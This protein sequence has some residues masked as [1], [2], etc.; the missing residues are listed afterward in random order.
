MK[1]KSV[2][3]SAISGVAIGG[4][5][6]TVI[7]VGVASYFIAAKPTPTD[8]PIIA[9]EPDAIVEKEPEVA[10]LAPDTTD[11]PEVSVQPEA[12][13]V[14]ELVVV[15]PASEPVPV[16]V[17]EPEP[18]IIPEPEVVAE[19][20]VTV[21]P[22]V[23][24]AQPKTTEPEPEIV[25]EQPVTVEPAIEAVIDPPK[26]SPP[27]FDLVRVDKTGSAVVAGKAAPNT[28]VILLLDGNAIS[29]AQTDASGAFV[30]LLDFDPSD[31]PRELTLVQKQPDQED[32]ASVGKVLIMPFK[33]KAVA[34]PKL[35]VASPDS[36][37][38]IAPPKVRVDTE[39]TATTTIEVATV[40]DLSL[41]T[42]VYDDLGDVVISGRGNSSD[43][44]R[45]YLDNK[46]AEVQKTLD[47]GQWK[48]TLTDVPD[49]L[50]ALRVDSV[51]AAGVVTERVQS[52]FKREKTDT[53][54]AALKANNSSVTI[55]PGYTLWALAENRYG[56]GVRYVQIFEANRQHIRDPDL[57]YPG[58]IFDLPN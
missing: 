26:V 22:E 37:E 35:V 34:A 25:D 28:T 8:V 31:A 10:I 4:A 1:G 55:Q 27:S 12:E 47:D 38:V 30:A 20:E 2:S 32:L 5:V 11:E 57:I 15:D 7:V 56:D 3:N 33:P 29:E 9:E 52:P 54:A 45:I 18:T 36:V 21:E 53:I 24:E 44:I 46:P 19:P 43:F 40:E 23:V 58:Q 41:D 50:Y 48:I 51:D 14:A 39:D 17:E 13:V 49:G 16:V 42:I 6:A